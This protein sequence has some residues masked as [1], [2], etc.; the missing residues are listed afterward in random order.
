M[1][2]GILTIDYNEPAYVCFAPIG[3]VQNSLRYCSQEEIKELLIELGLITEVQ[4][5]T[6]QDIVLRIPV[7]ISETQLKDMKLAA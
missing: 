7:Q 6:C 5:T 1:R 3:Q 4:F 2:D